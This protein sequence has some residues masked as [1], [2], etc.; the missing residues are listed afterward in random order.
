MIFP[1]LFLWTSNN[2]EEKVLSPSASHGEM[3]Q[4]N[5]PLKNVPLTASNVF[6]LKGKT[7]PLGTC[8][9]I[10]PLTQESQTGLF[11]R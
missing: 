11:R 4:R 2:I 8:L 3:K 5:F 10:F 1:E 9:W 7:P 6:L